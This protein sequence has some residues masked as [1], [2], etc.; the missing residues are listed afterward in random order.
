MGGLVTCWSKGVKLSEPRPFDWD[1][2]EAIN[3]KHD[4]HEAFWV[5][6]LAQDEHDFAH[7]QLYQSAE[8]QSMHQ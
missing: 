1:E 4:G 3:R 5:E 8:D 7:V 6:R 2:F